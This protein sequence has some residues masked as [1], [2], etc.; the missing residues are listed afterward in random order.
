MDPFSDIR[1]FNDNEVSS[2]LQRLHSDQAFLNTI[3]SFSFPRLNRYLGPLLRCLIAWRLKTKTR[4]LKTVDDVQLLVETYV[5]QSI[6]STCDSFTISGL[7]HLQDQQAHLLIAN[8]RDIVMDPALVT[9]A[10]YSAKQ[11]TPRI[12]IGDNLLQRPF[13]SDLMRL[14]KSFIVKRSVEGRRE[15]LAAFLQLSDYINH[16]ISQDNASIWIAQAEGRA[17]DGND[18]TDSAI[19]KMFHMSRKDE[20]FAQVIQS[21]H[22]MPI[23]ISYEYDPCD[24]AK[25]RE[26]YMLDSTGEYNKASGEDDASIAKGITGYKGRVH[27]HFCPIIKEASDNPK[28]LAKAIDAQIIGNYQLRPIHYL[29]WQ[30]WNKRNQQLKVIPPEFSTEELNKAKAYLAKRSTQCPAEHLP[31]LI[32]QYANPVQNYYL[33]QQAA[34]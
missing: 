17:K 9:Y 22:L 32:E 18:E 10:M 1:P 12:A 30:Q 14:N 21:L 25:A 8:H 4:A 24:L 16:S 20:D 34:P 33:L 6:N 2:I 28:A 3:S 29:A 27:I 26:L 19:L 13:V 31:Y 23:S 11:A 7:E 5:T 15:K